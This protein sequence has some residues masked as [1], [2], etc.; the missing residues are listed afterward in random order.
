MADIYDDHHAF[1]LALLAP[2]A[3]VWGHPRPDHAVAGGEQHIASVPGRL[4]PDPTE[5]RAAGQGAQ[6]LLDAFRTQRPREIAAAVEQHLA[7]NEK[8]AFSRSV[9]GGG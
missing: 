9:L 4:D 6:A 1:H 2:A 8:I 5:A 3:T 7:R